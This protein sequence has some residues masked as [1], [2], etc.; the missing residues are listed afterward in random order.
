MAYHVVSKST[1][2]GPYNKRRGLS[3][4]PNNLVEFLSH[5]QLVSLRQMEVFGWRLSFIRRMGEAEAVTIVCNG[6]RCAKLEGDGSLNTEVDISFR[7]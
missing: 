5:Q 7:I 4:V 1:T 3:P 6:K 2:S